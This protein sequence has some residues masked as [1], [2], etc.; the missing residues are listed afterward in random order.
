MNNRKMNVVKYAIA[1]IIFA[2]RAFIS[3]KKEMRMFFVRKT[4]RLIETASARG[5]NTVVV[6][7][8]FFLRFR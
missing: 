3:I 7:T 2:R 4:L 5:M 6:L 1:D 8:I